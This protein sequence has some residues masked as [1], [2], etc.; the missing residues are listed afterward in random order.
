MLT[1]TDAA[2]LDWPEVI[3]SLVG[4]APHKRVGGDMQGGITIPSE[5]RAIPEIIYTSRA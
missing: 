1:T 5:A 2:K 3:G 4:N